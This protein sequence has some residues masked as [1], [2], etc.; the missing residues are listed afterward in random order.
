MWGVLIYVEC[1]F[2]RYGQPFDCGLSYQCID[3]RHLSVLDQGASL[4]TATH[5]RILLGRINIYI[6]LIVF[7][8][9]LILVLNKRLLKQ[10]RKVNIDTKQKG[11]ALLQ[12]LFK[13]LVGSERFELSTNGL[14]VRCSTD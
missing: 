1:V 12:V 5:P 11:L 9:I 6:R 14:K 13:F 3:A 2:C 8:F 4:L 10:E 7:L